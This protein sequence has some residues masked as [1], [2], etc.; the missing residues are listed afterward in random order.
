MTI[1]A[2]PASVYIGPHDHAELQDL[3]ESWVGP[4]I[5]CRSLERIS[6]TLAWTDVADTD[7]VFRVEISDDPR[8]QEDIMRGTDTATWVEITYPAGS[9]DGTNVT[10]TGK[11]ATIAETAGSLRINLPRLAEWK[12][13]KYVATDGGDADQLT[14]TVSGG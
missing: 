7:G 3:S 2:L 6:W 8:V 12:R 1:E 14:A 9:T 10:V 5:N 4:P 11:N 13:L